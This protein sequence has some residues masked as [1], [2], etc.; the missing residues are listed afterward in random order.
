[1][2]YKRPEI[3]KYAI[4]VNPNKPGKVFRVLIGA[5]KFHGG[6][7]NKSLLTGPDLYK[8]LINVL[9]WFRENLFVVSTDIEGIFLR[10]SYQVIFGLSAPGGPH[11]K[12]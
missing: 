3:K 2:A 12:C 9:Q 7:P 6:F 5:A 4:I 11:I 1:M 10:V 8:N